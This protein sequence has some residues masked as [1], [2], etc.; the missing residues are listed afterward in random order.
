MPTTLT[1]LVLVCTK[2]F[3]YQ[4][5]LFF[6][7]KLLCVYQIL[8]LPKL[9]TI[10]SN[11][12]FLCLEIVSGRYYC[13]MYTR[14]WDFWK[15]YFLIFSAFWQNANGKDQSRLPVNLWSNLRKIITLF[16]KNKV[17]PALKRMDT[18]DPWFHWLEFYSWWYL[19]ENSGNVVPNLLPLK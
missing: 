8:R 16:L 18:Q 14:I 13:A 5:S 6:T 11:K 12:I 17:S 7:Q 15:E 10:T 4:I 19:N 3:G 9:G 1:L 2:F